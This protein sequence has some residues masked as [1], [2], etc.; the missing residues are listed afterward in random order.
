[1]GLRRRSLLRAAALPPL[2][3]AIPFAGPSLRPAA[4]QAPEPLTYLGWSQEEAAS[5]PVLTGL[6]DGFAAANPGVKLEVI[7]FPW[8]QMQQNTILR[9]RSGQRLDVVQL[10]E[11]WL[12]TLAPLGNLTDLDALLGRAWMEERIDPGLLRLGQIGGKQLALP[13]T[14]GSLGMVANAKVLEAGGLHEPPATLDAFVEGLRAIKKAQPE[15]VPF[16]LCTK[17]NASILPDFQIVLWSLGGRLLDDA[18]KVT[19]A[20]EAGEKTLTLLA[21]LVKEGLAARDV[22]RPDSRR[23]FAQDR[24]G[25]YFD[26][27]LAR[28]FARDNSGRGKAVDGQ[29]LAVATPVAKPGD[30]PKSV[31]WGHLLALPV[32]GGRRPA[33]DGAALRLVQHLALNDASQLRYFEAVG[34]FP[35]TKSALATLSGDA[36]VTNWTKLAAT[37]ERDEPSK[38]PNAA[39]IVTVVGEEVQGALLGTKPPRAALDDM[40]RRLEARMREVR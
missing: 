37:A 31:M 7:G 30:A 16:A 14:A 9:I 13:W 28:G 35:V 19:V 29:V 12:P 20:S 6:L 2:A 11:R 32:V 34:L 36:Y 33:R 26:A 4:A 10:Q 40:A 24:A 25:F 15:S 27:P 23:L 22:D 17:N 18:G 21:M 3:A 5:K 1:M 39:D 38:W 8:A